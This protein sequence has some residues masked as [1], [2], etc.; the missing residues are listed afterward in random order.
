MM[1]PAEPLRRTLTAGLICALV[2]SGGYLLYELGRLQG[3]YAVL[4]QRRVRIE[5]QAALAER[6]AQTEELR[7]Q[8]ALL[9]TSREIDRQPRWSGIS[10]SFRPGSRRRTRNWRFTRGSW[11]RMMASPGS[12]SRPC[13]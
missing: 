5:L 10:A 8:I 1:R 2:L 7:R 11:R 4:D 13:R 3:G 6:D 12:E 9:E